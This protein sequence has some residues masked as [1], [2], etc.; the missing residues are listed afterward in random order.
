M[1]SGKCYVCHEAFEKKGKGYKRRSLQAF[2]NP[3]CTVLA[4]LESVYGLS[5]SLED[6]K[7][8]FICDKCFSALCKT[9]NHTK[10]AE[11]AKG[12]LSKRME[13]DFA[14][15][16]C[17]ATTPTPRKSKKLRPS[18]TPA[19]GKHTPKVNICLE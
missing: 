5:L 11:F 9:V 19:K 10:E 17:L 6:A 13:G 18:A 3:T 7:L 4:G 15:K 16:R 8:D 12:E 1:A 2:I 14:R